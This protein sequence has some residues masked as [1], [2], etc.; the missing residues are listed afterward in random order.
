MWVNFVV[1]SSLLLR[2]VAL[3]VLRFTFLL[4]NQLFQIPIRPGMVDEGPLCSNS[5]LISV[6]DPGEGT[7]CPPPPLFLDENEAR[8]AE[9]ILIEGGPPLSQGL[10]PPLDMKTIRF[11]V[12]DMFPC[13]F[14]CLSLRLTETK[15]AINASGVFIDKSSSD[16]ISS[17]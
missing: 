13:C 2:E 7:G 1:G 4:K 11:C 5:L 10:D 17:P 16:R 12:S 15:F 8:R 14:L 9:K 6:A 3:W